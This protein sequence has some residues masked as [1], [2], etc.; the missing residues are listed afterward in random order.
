VEDAIRAF[1]VILHRGVTGK[2]Y[3]IGGT[4][5]KANVEVAKDLIRLMGHGEK[6]LQFVEDR[7]TNGRP[8]IVVVSPQYSISFYIFFLPS[9]Y[10]SISSHGRHSTSR[11]IIVVF[12]AHQQ[13]LEQADWKEITSSALTH[14][15]LLLS[16]PFLPS[17]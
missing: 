3:N 13:V 4:N 12:Y 10:S 17:S 5:E 16:L 14:P 11:A 7:A 9:L 2:I 6:M 15:S 8:F 1:E